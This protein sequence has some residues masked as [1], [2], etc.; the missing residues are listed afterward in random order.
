[1]TRFIYIILILGILAIGGAYF[2]LVSSGNGATDPQDQT[3]LGENEDLSGDRPG[4]VTFKNLGPAPEFKKIDSWLNGDPQTIAALQNKVILV[5]FWTYSCFTCVAA[6]PDLNRWSE[7]YKANGLAVIGVHTP[8]Y[9]FEKVPGNVQSAIDRFQ[10]KYPIALDN[11]YAT[12]TA[13]KN[14]FWPALYLVDRNG[15][16]MYTHYGDGG[17]KTTEKAIKLLLGLE[18]DPLSPIAPASDPNQVKSPVI[19][20]GLKH[21]DFF[22]NESLPSSQEKKYR[23]PDSLAVN[24]FALDGKWKLDN[25]KITLTEGFGKIQVKFSAAKVYL[26]ANTKVLMS[27][28]ITVDGKT[29]LPINVEGADTYTLF[30]SGDYGEHVLEIEIPAGGFEATQF[31]FG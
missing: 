19:P 22:A 16:I 30:D 18:T 8:Q 25:E 11:S 17:L 10:I 14:Q 21:L 24:T 26:K 6:L 31:S 23:L 5:N 13:Y 2:W 29:Q 1:M 4:R 28:K 7:T 12:W 20:L 27:I 15:R 3:M 9:T